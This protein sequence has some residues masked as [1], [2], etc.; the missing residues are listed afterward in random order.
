[1]PV[2][3]VRQNSPRCWRTSTRHGLHPIIDSV[4]PFDQLADAQQQM[5]D[6]TFFGKI[7]VTFD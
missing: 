1:M 3:T 5:A 7:V 6:G 4:H 2:A